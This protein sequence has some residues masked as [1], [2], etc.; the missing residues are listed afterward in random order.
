MVP[1]LVLA[2]IWLVLSILPAIGFNPWPVKLLSFATFAQGGLYGG[3]LAMLGGIIGK[4]LFAFLI[5]ALVV[6]LIMGKS[7]MKGFGKGFKRFLTGFSVQGIHMLSPLLTGIGIALVVFNFLS[8]NSSLVNSMPGLVIFVLAVR[9]L[10]RQRGFFWNLLHISANKLS[11]GMRPASVTVHR[12]ISGFATGG[13]A[14]VGLSSLPW[15]YFP[16]L[17]G[18]ALAIVGIVL[19]IAAKS[20]K[21]AVRI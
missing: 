10:V 5:S 1:M 17:L 15:P 21:E 18:L 13:L 6:P 20:R 12:F 4:A 16:Y 8:G 9:T 11:K 19:G 7:T 14:G 2:G 3:F